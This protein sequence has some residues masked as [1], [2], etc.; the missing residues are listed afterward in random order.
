MPL[1]RAEMGKTLGGGGGRCENLVQWTLSGISKGD[2]SED[3]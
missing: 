1:E 2:P 3:S